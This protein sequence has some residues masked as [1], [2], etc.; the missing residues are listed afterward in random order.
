MTREP[1]AVSNS[2][3]DMIGNTPVVRLSRVTPKECHNIYLKLEGLNPTG[4]YKDRMARSMI[5]EAERRGDLRPGMTILEAT[6]GSTGSSLAFVSLLKNYKFKVVSSDAFAREKLRTMQALGASLDTVPCSP[7]GIPVDLIQSMRDR[8]TAIAG[9]RLYYYCDQFTNRDAIVGYESLGCELIQQFPNGIDVF[10]GSVGTAGMI[11]GVGR[12]LKSKWPTCRIVVLEPA[13][14]PQITRGYSGAHR[15]E[16]VSIGFLPPLLD[17]NI[18]DEARSIN[19]A[20]AR[21]MCRRLASE[22]GLLVGTSSGLNVAAA[23]QL[24]KESPTATIVTIAVDTGLK[25]LS[26]DLFA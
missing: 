26:S 7:G 4:S 24:A 3:L 12:V 23:V 17:H 21:L 16:G 14:S 22:E 6:A 9:D 8:A 18:Y 10:C 11:M 1:P 13:S 15:V 5:E 2:A 25:Y 19:E 20:D